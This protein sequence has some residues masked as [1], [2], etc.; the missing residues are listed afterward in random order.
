[1]IALPKS[2]TASTQIVL[3]TIN[4]WPTDQLRCSSFQLLDELQAYLHLYVLHLL[5]HINTVCHV[6]QG[7]AKTLEEIE[8]ELLRSSAE[9]AVTS[10][11]NGESVPM[12]TVDQLERKL[13]GQ[14][15][16]DVQPASLPPTTQPSTTLSAVLT[17]GS[18]PVTRI[19]GLLPIVPGSIPV[20]NSVTLLHVTV[21]F[22]PLIT[23]LKLQS[24]GPS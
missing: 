4:K 9:S 2:R 22:N 23:T 8:Q 24:N 5:L 20:C 15:D 6:C 1:M 14:S 12:L 21:I 18:V 11:P 13:R 19:P 3:I 7:G 10:R 16:N 17:G